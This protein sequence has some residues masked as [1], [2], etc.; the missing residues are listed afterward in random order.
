MQA[1][2]AKERL[3]ALLGKNAE[4]RPAQAD[5]AARATGAFRPREHE[6][7]PNLM[8]L[9]AGTGIG[10][11]LGYIAPAS[12]WAE[13]NGGAVWISTFTKNLQRQLDQELDRL[14]PDPLK[15]RRKAVIRKGR[16]NYLCLLNLE[17]SGRAIVGGAG[18]PR[19][20]VMLGLVSRWARFSRDGDMVGG[21][22]PAW[23][24]AHFTAARLAEFTDRRG[25]C[26]YSACAHYRR[27]FIE[28]AVRRSKRAEIVVANHALVMV[29]AAMGADED[30]M[31]RHVVF[32]EGHHLFDAADSAYSLALSGMEGVELRRWIRGRETERK[33]RGRGLRSRIDELVMGDGEANAA[34]EDVILAA[35]D[36][37]GPGWLKRLSGAAPDG[38]MEAFL[39]ELRAH[40]IARAGE[41]D[42]G[43]GIEAGISEPADGLLEAAQ[44]LSKALDHLIAPMGRL[45]GLLAK[46]LDREAD[47][48]ES[49]ERGRIESAM[50]SLMLRA[51]MVKG[52][53]AMLAA[54]G[55]TVPEAFTDWAAIQRFQGRDYDIGLHRHWVD[56][57]EP[58]AKTVLEATQ[59]A[60]ITSA[61]LRDRRPD[62]EEPD[63]RSAEARTGAQ[64][65][66]LPAGRD[67]F[68][69]PFD[70][71]NQSRVI[72]VTDISKRSADQV[73]SAYRELI[74]ASGGGA[75]G[76]F[77]AIARLKTV[78][79]RIAHE[80]ESSGL[81]LYAQHVEPMDTGTLVDIFRGNLNAS[82][83]G[84][85]AVRDGV[86]VPGDALRLLIFDRVPWPRP[87][88][89]HRA[90]RERFGG[91]EYDDQLVRFRLKQAYGRLIRNKT[92]RGIFVMLDAAT[93]S[94]LTTAF[95][96]GVEIQRLGLADTVKEVRSF[97]APS[98]S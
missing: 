47:V 2:A 80:L 71:P 50:R 89:L 66:I 65:L 22:F 11:T 44:I 39:L 97:F 82:L 73:A 63:W 56:P 59:G 98:A 81:D 5:Y 7:A 72:V 94:R 96:E 84:T 52:W 32:D 23:L 87:T 42:H 61:T 35:R 25:E 69:S 10:K 86:D 36:L 88:I 58:F 57:T 53:R 77:T 13:Q 55:E 12:L 48:L 83:L 19:D 34:L 46:L 28:K 33:R 20:V 95:P 91:R 6:D 4:A 21:D 15:K 8:L 79:H 16:E 31:P 75:L 38:V 74:R 29:Q 40:V 18:G 17:E 24:G 41:V 45:T 43:H 30:W 76:L 92:D 78:Y 70:Y 51:D 54:L 1:D 14:Y 27:C 26:V 90:R 62:E 60:L 37:A 64:H 9:D 93:P 68:T 85:D 67:S 49:A 3:A